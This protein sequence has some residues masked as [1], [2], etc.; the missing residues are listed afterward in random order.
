MSD[1]SAAHITV[2]VGADRHSMG[3]IT[4]SFEEN[5]SPNTSNGSFS[6]DSDGYDLFLS[7]HSYGRSGGEG[8]VT[9]EEAVQA[10]WDEFIEHAGI[11]HD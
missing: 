2:H 3:D 5:A 7:R 9:F 4:Y 1:R 11:S 8:R 10:L 6:V